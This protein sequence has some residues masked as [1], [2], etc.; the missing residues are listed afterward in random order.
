MK[1]IILIFLLVPL[2][3]YSQTF[4]EMVEKRLTKQNSKSDE[5]DLVDN[6]KVKQ[7]EI[8]NY[9][10]G[11]LQN[12]D[13]KDSISKSNHITTKA[14][15]DYDD[16]GNIVN[17]RHDYIV[18]FENTEYKYDSSKRL[19]KLIRSQWYG[20]EEDYRQN[21][22]LEYKDD[23]INRYVYYKNDPESIRYNL[24]YYVNE[25]QLL[26]RVEDYS[27]YESF[28]SVVNYKYNKDEL[29]NFA[30]DTEI[31]YQYDKNKN[32]I[33]KE[34]FKPNHDKPKLYYK[35]DYN[36]KQQL[37]KEQYFI[38]EKL[39]S[40]QEYEYKNNL[41]FKETIY[42]GEEKQHYYLYYY[43]NNG[44]WVRREYYVDPPNPKRDNNDWLAEITLRKI[45]YK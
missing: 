31:K 25:Q 44:N 45:T 17:Y 9:G 2:L 40:K 10:G 26:S 24:K 34:Y 33:L 39:S 5:T 43:D 19:I 15:I 7:M 11:G 3:N 18:Y 16:I 29:V 42:F 37:I 21:E 30:D 36:D 28:N 41:L 1:K 35:Y 20:K 32:L 14:K 12:F 27:N 13:K 38:G 22:V 4:K 8:I 23:V 6:S